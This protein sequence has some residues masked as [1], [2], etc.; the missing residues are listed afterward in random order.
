[1][2][3]ARLGQNWELLA[4]RQEMHRADGA[5]FGSYNA[6]HNTRPKARWDYNTIMSFIIH[7]D[8][9][10]LAADEAGTIR[11]ANT[12]VTLETLS[13]HFRTGA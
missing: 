8:P 9:V 3:R 10:P 12:R 7:A 1:M 4:Q 11:V 5:E 2:D 13:E 6:A